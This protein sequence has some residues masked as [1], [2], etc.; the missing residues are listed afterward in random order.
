MAGASG[1]GAYYPAGVTI[2]SNVELILGTENADAGQAAE[3]AA[4]GVAANEDAANGDAAN[5]D[6]ADE[7]T[8]NEEAAAEGAGGDDNEETASAERRSPRKLID[9]IAVTDDDQ[10]E[11]V[12]LV[13]GRRRFKA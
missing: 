9:G 2:S 13:G 10:E 12:T 6:A 5:E 1:N 7:N 11:E 3:D 8:G 4:N